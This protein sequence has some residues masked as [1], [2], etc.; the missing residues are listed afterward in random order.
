M[1]KRSHKG[2]PTWAKGPRNVQGGNKSKGQAPGKGIGQRK[3]G[4]KIP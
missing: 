1:S 4:K 3:G 2:P